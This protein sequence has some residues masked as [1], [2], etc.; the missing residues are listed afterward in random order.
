[1]TR[2]P[3]PA[4]PRAIA[5]PLIPPPTTKIS[6]MSSALGSVGVAV[7]AS[8]KI[9]SVHTLYFDAG[10][11]NA[12][13]SPAGAEI[14]KAAFVQCNRSDLS[15]RTGPPPFR[16]SHR[17]RVPGSALPSP[18]DRRLTAGPLGKKGT[19]FR[20]LLTRRHNYCLNAYIGPLS[21]CLVG[22]VSSSDQ[23]RGARCFENLAADRSARRTSRGAT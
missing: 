15:V 17:R 10:D 13:E 1:M 2:A 21:C 3:R 5:A 14:A 22:G 16:R 18:G 7:I 20:F 11:R 19:K 23:Q 6:N 8:T 9:P 12:C 4:A